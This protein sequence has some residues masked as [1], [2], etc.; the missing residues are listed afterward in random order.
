MFHIESLIHPALDPKDLS[1]KPIPTP[2][3]VSNKKASMCLILDN[4]A[5][6]THADFRFK[7]FMLNYL[8]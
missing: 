5:Y 1:S 6:S 7:G 3:T 2:E 8:I 4:E